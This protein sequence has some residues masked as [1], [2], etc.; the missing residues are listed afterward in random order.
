MYQ[1]GQQKTRF[2]GIFKPSSGL[3]PETPSLAWG[4]P[5]APPDVSDWGRAG[6]AAPGLKL[7]TKPQPVRSSSA[8]PASIRAFFALGTAVT[9]GFLCVVLVFEISRML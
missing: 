5:P 3:E 8:W 2:T 7:L 4:R 9:L 6:R 1:S